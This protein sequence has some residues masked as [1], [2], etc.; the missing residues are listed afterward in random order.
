[1]VSVSTSAVSD[2]AIPP[3]D[4]ST[5]RLQHLLIW[6]AIIALVAAALVIRVP[7]FMVVPRLSDETKEVS[8]GLRIARGEALPLTN[9]FSFGGSLF[10]FLVAGVFLL[11]GERLEAGRILVLVTGALTVIPTYLL[12]CSLAGPGLRGQLVGLMAAALLAAS[13]TH[14]VVTSRIAYAHS[15]TPFFT[16]LGLWLFHRTLVRG[17]GPLLVA[18]G[19]TFGLALQMHPSALA[20][21]PGLGAAL[22]LRGRPLLAEQRGRWIALAGLAAIV[23]VWN[24]L[25]FNLTHDFESVRRAAEQSDDY[26]NEGVS[27]GRG[28]PER[29]VVLLRGSALT[30]GSRVSEELDARTIAAP[31][32]LAMVALVLLGLGSFARRREWLPLLVIV[33]G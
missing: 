9:S 29:M 18:S 31:L 17:S 8:V 25:V 24:L 10:N 28:W 13:A 30:L 4:S 7:G 2:A 21:W 16:T 22:L 14:T 6:A 26:V 15:L 1:M 33:S 12:G 3:A 19:F 5:D 32:V 20:I 23:A 11:V 27:A